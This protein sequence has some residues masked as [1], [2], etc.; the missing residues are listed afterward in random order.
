MLKAE[1]TSAEKSSW[2]KAAAKRRGARGSGAND[3]RN[4]GAS[5]DETRGGG[6]LG[7]GAGNGGTLDADLPNVER[8]PCKTQKSCET[9]GLREKRVQ[10]DLSAIPFRLLGFGVLLGWHFLILYFPLRLFDD[11]LISEALFWR[12]VSLNG[13]L[14]VFFFLFGWIM[15]KVFPRTP[16]MMGTVLAAGTVVATVGCAGALLAPSASP[17]LVTTTVAMGAGEAILMLLW[18]QFYSETS[19]NYSCYYLAASAVIGSLICFFTRNLTSELALVVF[20]LLPVVSAGMLHFGEKSTAR[21]FDEWEGAGTPNWE[22]AR[23]PFARS[24]AQLAIFGLIF[25]MFQGSVGAHGN[26]L[27]AVAEPFSVLGVG[28]AGLLIVGLYW[29]S[30]VRPN[31]SFVHKLSTLLFTGGLMLVPFA[32]DVLVNVAATAVMTG[33]VLLET[34]T[35]I[36]M[37]DLV[38]TFDIK[39]GFTIGLNRGLEYGSF[40]VGIVVGGILWQN[41]ENMTGFSFAFVSLAVFVGITAALLLLDEKNIWAADFYLE[42]EK[43]ADDALYSAHTER[44]PSGRWRAAC[45]KICFEHGLS[46]RESEIFLLM[47]KG[48]NAEYIQNALFISNHTAKTHI[49]NIYRKLDVHSAQELL[50]LVEDAKEEPGDAKELARESNE[51]LPSA[52]PS[53]G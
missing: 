14:F 49:A 11:S 22:A 13:S 46:P 10:S 25:G 28:L 26:V 20:V 51:T 5:N 39:A 6:A 43:I 19:V 29:A 21:R 17:M 23:R 50:D 37:V 4:S 27:L 18:L 34:I 8:R 48:R 33:F 16:K 9:E 45:N 52:T 47:A 40:T 38:R 12:Q 36:L 44:R 31:L 15:D 7:G 42:Q 1:E 30:P 3:G 24:T 53:N 35:L 41:F 32:K 2:K